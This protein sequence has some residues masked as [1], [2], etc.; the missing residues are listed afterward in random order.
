M[1][2]LTNHNSLLLLLLLLLS[3]LLLP[4]QNSSRHVLV[5]TARAD[6]KDFVAD[7]HD[8]IR[9]FFVSRFFGFHA[10]IDEGF[11]FF[12]PFRIVLRTSGNHEQI[13]CFSQRQGS[14]LHSFPFLVVL[15]SFNLNTKHHR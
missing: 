7:F 13:S 12:H 6:V 4:A 5:V 3:L 2:W 9:I 15:W 8:A 10:H 14:V 1:T 11:R